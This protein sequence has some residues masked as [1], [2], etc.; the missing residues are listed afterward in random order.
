VTREALARNAA[1]LI[2]FHC[3]PSGN[4]SPSAADE[5]L[6]RR[7]VAG[8]ALLDIRVLDHFIVGETITSFAQLGLL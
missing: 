8:L 6:T 1:S 5:A 2:L 7:V 4:P 3:H